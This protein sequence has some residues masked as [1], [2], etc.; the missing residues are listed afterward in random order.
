[1]QGAD[2]ALEEMQLLEAELRIAMF[3]TGSPNL[4]SLRIPGVLERVQ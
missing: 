4:S 1:V 2:A 3:C